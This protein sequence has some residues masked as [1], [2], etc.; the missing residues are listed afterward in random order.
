MRRRL[1]VS[2]SWSNERRIVVVNAEANSR[3]AAATTRRQTDDTYSKHG[4]DTGIGR[5]DDDD[6]DDDDP[7]A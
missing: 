4:V 3:P 2:A 6:D 5:S 1:R 7:C